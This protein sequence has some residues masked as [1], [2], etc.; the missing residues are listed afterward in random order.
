MNFIILLY[1]VKICFAIKC[2]RFRKIERKERFLT[3][4]WWRAQKQKHRSKCKRCTWKRSWTNTSH[5]YISGVIVCVTLETVSPFV[6]QESFLSLFFLV[7][8]ILHFLKPLFL[9]YICL[10][11]FDIPLKFFCFYNL[12]MF[13]YYFVRHQKW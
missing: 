5:P 12:S 10:T 2:Y 9:W 11:M 13:Y 1:F 4:K 8:V 7:F 6:W 3:N